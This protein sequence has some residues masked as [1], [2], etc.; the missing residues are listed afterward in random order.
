MHNIGWG[1]AR[2]STTWTSRYV[3]FSSISTSPP[4]SLS[5]SPYFSHTQL[6]WVCC[7]ALISFWGTMLMRL[8]AFWASWF[9]A[10]AC[11]LFSRAYPLDLPQCVCVRVLCMCVLC[12]CVYVYVCAVCI[13][14]SVHLCR[15][16][17]LPHYA[18][19]KEI[20]SISR[21]NLQIFH[22]PNGNV[23]LER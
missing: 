2:N 23:S 13:F 17:Q 8:I 7:C 9:T 3:N 14:V 12:V 10:A 22:L 16:Q 15:H 19:W 4:S 5:H 1:C 21:E 18:A 11:E 6:L 20:T